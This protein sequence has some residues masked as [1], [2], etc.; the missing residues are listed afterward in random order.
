MIKDY[1]KDS[2]KYAE[3]FTPSFA[4]NIMADILFNDTPV[5][6]V[7]VYDPAAGSG[8]LLLSMANKIGTN[9]CTIYSGYL[10]KSTQF[11][12]LI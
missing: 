3:Y 9:N 12:G 6:N 7:S 8:T 11:Y 1:N 10:A 2:G 4:G 5:T